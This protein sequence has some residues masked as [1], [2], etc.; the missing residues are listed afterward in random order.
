MLS[1]SKAQDSTDFFLKEV[2]VFSNNSFNT[3][4]QYNKLFGYGFSVGLD[5]KSK[6]IFQLKV[7]VGYLHSYRYVDSMAVPF[8]YYYDTKYKHDWLVFNVNVKTFL[9]TKKQFYFETGIN[10]DVLLRTKIYG[11]RHS[12]HLS[13]WAGY[14]TS[15]RYE[16]GL[17][18]TFGMN[19]V[20]PMEVGYKIPIRNV[21]LLLFVSYNLGMNH[22]K[23]YVSSEEIPFKNSYFNSG[24]GLNF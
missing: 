7:G 14:Q 1:S 23:E 19:I 18:E 6:S 4:S 3:S 21:F 12:T 8:G 20:L 11:Y 24:I 9:D 5:F 13:L 2:K 16:E 15:D 10:F 17:A 22:L